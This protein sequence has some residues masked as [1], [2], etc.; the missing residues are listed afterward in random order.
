[1]AGYRPADWHPLDLDRDPT[2]GDP[3]RVRT[4]ASQLHAFADDV[5][6][7]LRL[8]KGMAGEDTLLQW[9]G[10]SAEV[11]KEQFK[12]VPKN[13]KKLKKSYEMCGDALADYW[14]KLERAQAL[15]DKALAKAKEAQSDLSSAKSRLSSADSWVTR[16]TKEADKYKDDP[17][18]SKS[19]ADKPDEGKVRAATRDVQS[20]KSAHTKA[21]SDVTT[22]QNAL[23]AAK[24]MAEDAR[25]MRD[26]AAGEAKRKIDEAS[27]AGIPNRHWWQDV[28][29]W[30]EDNWDTIVTV[31]KVV[32]AVVGIIALI[33]GGPILGAIVLVAALVV[34]ADTLYKYSKGQ[35]SLWDV[36]FAALDCIPGG[37]GITSL[38]KLA[39]GLKEMKN[40]RGGMK[41]MSL[42]VR[43][44]GKNARGMLAE[45]A[46]GAFNRLKSVVRSKGSDPV[47]MAT[48]AMYL[49]QNDIELPGLLPLA[50]TRRVA[51]NYR[52]GW[53]FG[54]SWA[55]TLD[56]RLEVDDQGV[57]HV[58]EDG[59]L[60]AYP[61][62][63]AP[64]T[65]VMPEAGPRRPLTRH[66]DGGYRITDPL[67]GH[68]RHFARPSTDGTALLTRISDRNQHTITFEYDEH[69]TPL[70]IRHSGGYHLRITIDEGRVTAIS[71]VG[72]DDDGTDVVI[73][74]YGY[75]D[76]NLTETI[77]SSGL[78]LRF[79]YDD[80]LRVTSWT[81]TNNSRYAYTYDDRDR[82]IAEGGEAGHITITLD[83]DGADPAWPACRITTLTTA[84]GAVTRFVVNTNSQVIAE[85]D[86]LGNTT[87]TSYDQHHHVL[88]Q[89]DALGHTTHLENNVNGQP[90]RIFRPDGRSAS[91]EFNDLALPV[92]ITGFDGN[93]HKRTYDERGNQVSSTDPAGGESH[94]TYA[95]D[96]RITSVTNPLGHTTTVRCDK[97][98]LPIEITDPLGAVTRYERDAFGRRVALIDATGAI[99]RLE[100]TT[101][102]HL[103]RRTAPDATAESWSY[104][105]EGNCIRHVDALG[106]IS[107]F[108][109]T[110]FDLLASR[111]GPDS[112]RYEFT[113]DSQLRLTNVRNPQG[114]TWAY[115]YDAAGNM[116][117]ETDFD[118]RALAY[119]YDAAGR[120]ISRTNAL[121]QTVS[122]ERNPMGQIVRKC[123]AGRVTTYS[124]GPTGY[125]DEA[126]GP[127]A[128][129]IFLRDRVG[130]LV[131]ET[132]NE[133]TLTYE[134][135][136]LGRRTARSTPSGAR[137]MWTY[138]AAGNRTKMVASGRPIS[139]T[140]DSVGREL[141]RHIGDEAL[142]LAQEYDD[143]GRLTSQSLTSPRHRHVQQ[144][145]YLY[146]SD[147]HVIAIED[148]LT[149]VR[150]FEL[151]P[152]GRVT[153]VHAAKW[154]E[155]Y[156]YDASGNQEAASWPESHP[157]QEAVGAREYEGTRIVRAGRVR[158]KHD[159]LGRMT[160]RQKSRL[161]R[162]P[163]TWQYEWD[164]ED[165]LTSVITPSGVRWRY[166]YDPLGRRTA[167]LR[168]AEDGE[169]VVERV[170]FTW[171]GTTLCEQTTIHD[172]SRP[173][174]LTWDYQGLRPVAQTER[175]SA[176]EASHEEIDSR[177]F[178][179]VS[180][181]VGSP[182]ELVDE[183]GDIAWRARST[184]WGSTAWPAGSAAY[185]PL[186]FPGQY[187]DVETGLHYNYFRHYDPETAR[188]LTPDPLG[189]APSPNPLTYVDNPLVFA[190]PLGL[191]P[192]YDLTD[193]GDG[194]Y[195]SQAGLDYG[196]GSAEGHRILHVM[197]HARENPAKPRHG[198]YDTGS[199]GILETVDEAW[200]R[201][202]LAASVNQ[203]GAR[204]TYVIPMS[205]RVGLNEGE[206]YISITVEHGN[207]VITA[208]PRSWP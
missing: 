129:V 32:V 8:V 35:A 198:V 51:S 13:L 123:T 21:Q 141:I 111:T 163:L 34:L 1:M 29:H 196:P 84:E 168:L 152:V 26:D 132:V 67:T 191:A 66:D 28:G 46:E 162:K 16:A 71:L 108:E 127:D 53:W 52:C 176:S 182:S 181:L 122:F 138:D 81:D 142:T 186:R 154:T 41:A 74:R 95:E 121:G 183:Q 146:R 106:G 201:R 11:F 184:L 150:R 92:E 2:P 57:V 77:N 199:K 204:T 102:G 189:L 104:D 80:R 105:G 33:I 131:S 19:S 115:E 60:L 85:T 197:E 156:A 160:L 133:R 4:L 14:P 139:F 206:D 55:S 101:E 151:D 126:A 103:A 128:N 167:K 17:T 23:D 192:D 179:I 159:A 3:Q 88:A 147:G 90:T 47:D 158:Y 124:Y 155:R 166:E 110:H 137:T 83:Y 200:D 43:G 50:F 89:T 58:T 24:K 48:G 37:K 157:G 188:Y 86:P 202:A 134:Y 161:S 169:T 145:N 120:L 78:P 114:L 61:H 144:R 190:D 20:A 195:R 15:A 107:S 174:T 125:M 172:R 164:P 117:C 99:T 143:L 64:H 116:V 205:R 45:G 6:D 203:Q 68:T 207:E 56:E 130:R 171:D 87:R 65:P 187:Y 177:F 30:F 113:H 9:A 62:P 69:G 96:G 178:A 42:A 180:D 39:K 153:A 94:L 63:A 27:D 59:L 185:T 40:L 10:K 208:F 79:T 82:C 93:T 49:P 7:A 135:D 75:T 193:L 76:G 12:D 73:K 97:A 70:A 136:A 118:G 54:P 31:C 36:A 112:V 38:G 91:V 72:A 98:G 100:W 25:K 148:Q 149:G 165:R 5:S 44:L 194:W 175:I 18:G 109:Y 119:R 173:V 170:D 140:Y 22:A